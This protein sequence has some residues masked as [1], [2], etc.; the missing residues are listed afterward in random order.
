MADYPS[1]AFAPTTKNTGD[2]IA[3]SHINALQAEVTAIEA[4][5]LTTGLAHN[6]TVTGTLTVTAK[7]DISGTGSNADILT[8][9]TAGTSAPGLSLKNATT[10]TLAQILASNAL[11]LSLLT[12]AGNLIAMTLSSTCVVTITNLA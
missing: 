4:A 6:V 1:S 5:L 3:A 9:T 11:D 8:L 7:A 10:G 12:N 2:T